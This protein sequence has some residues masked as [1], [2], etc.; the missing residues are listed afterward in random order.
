M[1]P[2]LVYGVSFVGSVLATQTEKKIVFLSLGDPVVGR[3]EQRNRNSGDKRH[4]E[5]RDTH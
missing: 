2:F 4:R 1:V 5:I 3:I